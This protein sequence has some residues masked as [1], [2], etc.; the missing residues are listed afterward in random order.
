MWEPPRE[1]S[2]DE[3][4]DESV[5]DVFVGVNEGF[6]ELVEIERVTAARVAGTDGREPEHVSGVAQSP[7]P[8]VAGRS[9]VDQDHRRRDYT[10]V[11]AVAGR[12]GG[13][14]E[15]GT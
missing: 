10:G 3:L 15:V 6:A 9:V 13:V 2:V 7:D 12:P 8:R 1:L 4:L 5:D 14:A 11:S